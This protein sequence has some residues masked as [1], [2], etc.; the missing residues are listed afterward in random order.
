MK[1]KK[2]PAPQRAGTATKKDRA[3]ETASVVRDIELLRKRDLAKYEL[4]I[5][6]VIR[7]LVES[8][9]RSQ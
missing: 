8:A 5:Q 7:A 2:T 1:T 4:A 6:L 3:R 9:R